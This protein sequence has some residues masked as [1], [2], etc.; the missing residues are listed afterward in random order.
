MKI[1]QCAG[2]ITL[3][4]SMFILLSACDVVTDLENK[5]EGL[6]TTANAVETSF[7]QG[8]DL[9]ETGQAVIANVEGSG[10][11][12]TALALATEFQVSGMLETAQSGAAEKGPELLQT[13]Q[14]FASE[15]APKL[16]G[17][18]QAIT[19]RYPSP[20][21]L[22]V[23]EGEISGFQSSPDNVSYRI[24]AK[25]QDVV[26]FYKNEMPNSGWSPIISASLINENG[27]LIHYEKRD[28]KAV[29]A[30]NIDP[31]TNNTIVQITIQDD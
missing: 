18:A 28:R 30:I 23:M 4:V 1:R 20:S 22:P 7:Q 24:D 2:L 26:E 31:D 27:A 5:V 14:Y 19:T 21:D 10:I 15:Q 16:I 29:L 11:G 13:V 9:I 8:S 6:Q 25:M 3:L 12:Q 17:T